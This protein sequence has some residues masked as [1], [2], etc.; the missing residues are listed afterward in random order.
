MACRAS[1]GPNIAER[2][3]ALTKT[4][5][6]LLKTTL[7]NLGGTPHASPNR[8]PGWPLVR[9]RS[10][11]YATEPSTGRA[12]PAVVVRM[13]SAPLLSSFAEYNQHFPP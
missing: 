6:T 1:A 5:V 7:R 10:Q 4:L 9:A 13:V 12:N 8:R 11:G 2:F 3:S